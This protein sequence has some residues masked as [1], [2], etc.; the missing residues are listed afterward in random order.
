MTHSI[1]RKSAQSLV[2]VGTRQCA[3]FSGARVSRPQLIS[4][5][6]PFPH[7]ATKGSSSLGTTRFYHQSPIAFTAKENKQ[8]AE[9]IKEDAKTL[10][11]NDD[12]QQQQ[13]PGTATISFVE[14]DQEGA[15]NDQD[16]VPK[17]PIDSLKGGDPTAYTVPIEIKM[18]DMSD[19]DDD[20]QNI[21]E[22]WY[23][24]PG[25]VIKRND[26]LCDITTPAFTFGMVT[27]DEEDAVM[28]DIYVAEGQ[29]ASDN[30][31]ICTI[32]HLPEP[33]HNR[34]AGKKE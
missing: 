17:H 25:D 26:V 27:D 21:I 19:D 23:K 11:P 24:Q 30:A 3:I 7:S 28:G 33:E 10:T 14:T 12:E 20:D 18:P 31:P 29:A 4:A 6:L 15:F 22:K 9:E 13:P 16:D 5:R 1:L 34:A 32:Y 8:S 2:Q